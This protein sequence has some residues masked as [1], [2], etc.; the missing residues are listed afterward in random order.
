M[1]WA[2]VSSAI[3]MERY[4]DTRK[5]LSFSFFSRIFR[6]FFC[7]FIFPFA[8]W[9]QWLLSFSSRFFSPLPILAPTTFTLNRLA[10]RSSGK[11][12]SK[13][14]E[15]VGEMRKIRFCWRYAGYTIVTF[16]RPDTVTPLRRLIELPFS[17]N[18]TSSRKKSSSTTEEN[19]R[20]RRR[21]RS[22]AACVAPSNNCW[23]KK[24]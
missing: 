16:M 23:F 4:V 9:K 10:H 18:Q 22:F 6:F 20:F 13:P 14:S 15:N 2:K 21:R 5:I 12:K 1:R 17:R 7:F 11:K 8:E 19:F 3:T 24:L